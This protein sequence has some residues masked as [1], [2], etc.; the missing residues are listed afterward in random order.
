MVL[1]ALRRMIWIFPPPLERILAN[2]GPQTT[3][4]AV[5]DRHPHAGCPEIDA[6]DECHV[7]QPR[8]SAERDRDP[9]LRHHCSLRRER[10][11]R[12]FFVWRVRDLNVIG[13]VPRH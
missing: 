12:A 1:V 8:F 11:A 10:E 9:Q 3:A 4:V 6:G 7:L 5:N 2:T 13:S